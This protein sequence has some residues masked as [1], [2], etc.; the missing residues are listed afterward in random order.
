MVEQQTILTLMQQKLSIMR[1]VLSLTGDE[2]RLVDLDDLEP[3]LEQKDVCIREMQL[4]D[5]ALGLHERIPPESAIIRDELAEV[6]E[7]ILENE[8]TLEAR[9]EQEHVRLRQELHDLDQETRLRQYLERA[10]PKGGT[11]NLKK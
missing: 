10:K 2:L 7:A 11:V 3:I 9:L 5:E 1:E 6:V 4:I 8:R